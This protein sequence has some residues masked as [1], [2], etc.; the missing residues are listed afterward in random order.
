MT[1]T[2]YADLSKRPLN[3]TGA[4][5][6]RTYSGGKMLERWKG[7]PEPSDGEFPE[8]WVA[9]TIQARNVG[10]EH[11]IEGL[12]TLQ[13]QG[14][15]TVELKSVIASDPERFLGSQHVEKYADNP[16]VLVKLIDSVERLSIY[17]PVSHAPARC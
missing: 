3:V 8:E 5:V 15:S 6:W 10:R 16:A 2:E 7:L 17:R 13:T 4:R 11:L 14:G 1:Q 12:S 9:S